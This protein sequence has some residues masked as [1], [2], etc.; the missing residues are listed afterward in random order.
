MTT[1]T[2]PRPPVV[3]RPERCNAALGRAF[4]ILGKRW[5]GVILGALSAGPAGF[6]ELSRAIGTISDSMLSDRLSELAAVGVIRREV[7][8]GPPVTVSYELTPAGRALDP[9]LA[10]LESWVRAHLPLAD[11]AGAALADGSLPGATA[12]AR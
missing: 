4:G 12:A 1:P 10:D 5:N 6:A 2:A 3:E 9:I 8:P 11:D 7:A